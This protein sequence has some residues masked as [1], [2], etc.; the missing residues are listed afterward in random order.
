MLSHIFAGFHKAIAWSVMKN[1]SDLTFT[2]GMLPDK[3]VK[4]LKRNNKIINL[5]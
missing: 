5:Q 4:Y 1:L 3:L 2:N